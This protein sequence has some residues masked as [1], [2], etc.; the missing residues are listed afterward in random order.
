MSLRNIFKKKEKSE[1]LKET[2]KDSVKLGPTEQTK[3]ESKEKLKKAERKEKIPAIAYKVL[4]S[5][6]ITEKA[7]DL[8]AKNQY[9]FKVF[10]GANKIQIKRAIEELYNVDVLGVKTIR[11]PRK[12]RRFGRFTG[13]R[14]GYK[15][16]MVKIRQG[17]KIDVMPK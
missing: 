3:E 1:E 15:K 14:S 12:P 2:P 16:A 7:T 6:H 11:V 13:Y 8:S 4:V 17:Q 9:I 10:P 5:P